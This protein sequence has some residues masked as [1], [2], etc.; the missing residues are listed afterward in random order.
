VS[1][2]IAR[3]LAREVVDDVEDAD[4]PARRD[5]VLPD[6]VLDLHPRVDLFQDP[7]DLLLGESRFS[8]LVP[9]CSRRTHVSDGPGFG[10]KVTSA[11]ETGK[12]ERRACGLGPERRMLRGRVARA[13]VLR[14]RRRRAPASRCCDRSHLPAVVGKIRLGRLRLT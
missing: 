5:P 12:S 11:C 6:E 7:D 4:T 10:G 8:H 14:G 2:S 13:T 3:Q 9:H 1:T